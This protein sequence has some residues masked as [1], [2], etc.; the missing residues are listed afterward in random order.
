MNLNQN[1]KNKK[2][3]KIK[4]KQLFAKVDY[5]LQEIQKEAEWENILVKES[6]WAYPREISFKSQIR[7]VYKQYGIYKK[8]AKDFS[9]LDENGTS[10]VDK[11]YTKAYVRHLF[12]S[13]EMLGK[14][15]ASL[16]NIRFYLWLMNEA[17]QRIENGEFTS[18]KNKMVKKLD[19]RL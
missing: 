18:W 13:N 11:T 4:T 10:Y 2:T 8:W 12:K 14:Q 7:K 6:K 1:T 5:D 17:R 19:V 15:I 16:H 9:L 3:G